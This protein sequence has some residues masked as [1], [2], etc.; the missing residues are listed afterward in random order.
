MR[1]YIQISVI[2]IWEFPARYWIF[3]EGDMQSNMRQIN[4]I[5]EN[6]YLKLQI[7]LLW[8]ISFPSQAW[9]WGQLDFWALL[10]CL[11]SPHVSCYP[12]R[13]CDV[14]YRYNPGMFYV[15][16]HKCEKRRRVRV[17]EYSIYFR[18]TDF[19][20]RQNIIICITTYCEIFNN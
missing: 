5:F 18:R 13:P 15:M 7:I 10:L 6:Q 1:I 3:A 16:T 17:L 11:I 8:D 20:M 14:V 2:W 12:H 9:Y 19:C 4:I